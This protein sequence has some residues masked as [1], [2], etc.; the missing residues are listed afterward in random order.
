MLRQFVMWLSMALMKKPDEIMLYLI[1]LSSPVI[2]TL[3]SFLIKNILKLIRLITG[4]IKRI[5]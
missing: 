4:L 3:G 2:Y 5:K 1:I